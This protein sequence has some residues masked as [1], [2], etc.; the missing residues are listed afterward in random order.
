M[1]A[2]VSGETLARTL[3]LMNGVG[4]NAILATDSVENLYLRTL[5]RRPTPEELKHWDIKGEEYLQDL[6]WA[7]LNSKEFGT[8]H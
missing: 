8:N 4:V 6:F 1:D 3:H 5:S 7:L 2:P